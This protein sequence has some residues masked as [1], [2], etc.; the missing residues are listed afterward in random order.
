MAAVYVWAGMAQAASLMF[1]N[2]AL[3]EAIN[4]STPSR[5][6]FIIEKIS[7]HFLLLTQK[8]Q[9]LSI[10]TGLIVSVKC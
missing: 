9:V 1:S 10:G 7:M 2:T 3:Q 8:F 6:L 4:Y 5:F